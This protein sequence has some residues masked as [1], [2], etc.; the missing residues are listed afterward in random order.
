MDSP[1]ICRSTE[2][3]VQATSKAISA[4]GTFNRRALYVL[5]QSRHQFNHPLVAHPSFVVRHYEC[6][7]LMLHKGSLV[8]FCSLIRIVSCA[9]SGFTNS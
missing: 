8:R 6:A 3:P 5:R 2:Y 7:H 1:Y 4:T 9:V